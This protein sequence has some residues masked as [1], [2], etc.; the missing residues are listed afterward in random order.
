MSAQDETGSLCQNKK[1][2][3]QKFLN[4]LTKARIRKIDGHKLK[5]KIG[6]FKTFNGIHVELLKENSFYLI[7]FS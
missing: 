6:T 2:Q 4:N 3:K 5:I 1:K 7:E